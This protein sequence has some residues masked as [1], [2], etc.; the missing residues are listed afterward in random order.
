M[1]QDLEYELADERA[2]V[3]ELYA[4]LAALS[5]CEAEFKED[6]S[7][8]AGSG[9]EEPGSPVGE[10]PNENVEKVP[11]PQAPETA[12]GPRR[13]M[14]PFH[15]GPVERVAMEHLYAWAENEAGN[16]QV[17]YLILSKV[18]GVILAEIGFKQS[19]PQADSVTSSNKVYKLVNTA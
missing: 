19:D 6:A 12:P 4:A 5:L 2:K 17:A 18:D 8:Q 7:T 9:F 11:V 3:P 14:K 15:I 13:N 16:R 1:T 10:G